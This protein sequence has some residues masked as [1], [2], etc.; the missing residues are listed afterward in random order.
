MYIAS[1]GKVSRRCSETLWFWSF[2]GFRSHL[3]LIGSRYPA[4]WCIAHQPHIRTNADQNVPSFRNVNYPFLFKKISM[5]GDTIKATSWKIHEKG[6][7]FSS[8]RLL[9]PS[10]DSH[11]TSLRT[12]SLQCGFILVHLL[13]LRWVLLIRNCT[14]SKKNGE[15]KYWPFGSE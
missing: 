14:R 9:L 13:F 5:L 11:A 1:S 10:S 15:E 2:G 7:H 8:G 6:S 4:R 12:I 3:P